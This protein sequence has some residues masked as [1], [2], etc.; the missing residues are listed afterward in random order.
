[1]VTVTQMHRTWHSLRHRFARNMLDGYD[2][3]VGAL[4]AIG[5]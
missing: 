1:M 5:G 4:T 2:M 3:S